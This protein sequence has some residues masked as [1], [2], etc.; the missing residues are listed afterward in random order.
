MASPIALSPD[1]LRPASTA[2]AAGRR[3]EDVARTAEAFEAMFLSS[4]L[5]VMF[6]GVEA[7]APFSGGP[8]ED[9]FKSFLNDAMARS[10]AKAGG[11]GLADGLK[12][13]LLKLQGLDA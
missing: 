8:G 3:P 10:M 11:I 5:G 6:K 4:M 1:L 9:A 7:E 13:E 2:P 12:R